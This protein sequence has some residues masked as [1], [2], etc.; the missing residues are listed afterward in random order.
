MR[1]LFPVI[2]VVLG[3]ATSSADTISFDL[4]TSVKR[5]NSGICHPPSTIY[6]DRVKDYDTMTLEE[7]LKG[8]AEDAT[9]EADWEGKPGRLPKQ[10]LDYYEA[11]LAEASCS[12]KR[13]P[14][15]LVCERIDSLLERARGEAEQIE[16]SK[17]RFEG[18]KFGIALAA[19]SFDEPIVEDV[20]IVDGIVFAREKRKIVT[21][22]M[23]EMHKF[24]TFP[25]TG[26]DF[27]VGPF[28]ATSL[29]E[30]DTVSTSSIVETIAAGIMIGWK[31]GPRESSASWNA[32][33]GL[34][35][36]SG[37]SEW[38][39]G[40]SDGATTTSL[41]PADLTRTADRTGAVLL[42]SASW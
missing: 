2:L 33:L 37:V 14:K 7:C 18:F 38:R 24:F 30:G 13:D 27:G 41:N 22:V 15:P 1:F 11:L 21:S 5:S 10:Y 40:V 20:A 42:F 16:T 28:V 31:R 4:G 6:Y 12:K 25:N 32:G 29:A 35:V 3:A 9:I 23:L 34:L 36:D 26:P 19:V 39:E 8:E 17:A